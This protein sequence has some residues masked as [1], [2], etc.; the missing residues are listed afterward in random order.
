M[1]Q[2]LAA[3]DTLCAEEGVFIVV[4][5]F[6]YHD[7]ASPWHVAGVAQGADFGVGLLL[8][9][10]LHVVDA[11]VASAWWTRRRRQASVACEPALRANKHTGSS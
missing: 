11:H 5:F 2:A 9:V 1:G 6:F 10:Q 4:H 3:T 8:E 7:I